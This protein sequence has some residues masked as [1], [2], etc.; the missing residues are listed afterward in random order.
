MQNKTLMYLL[1]VN[2]MMGELFIIGWFNGYA[3][4]ITPD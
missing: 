2:L 4:I 3:L 1:T